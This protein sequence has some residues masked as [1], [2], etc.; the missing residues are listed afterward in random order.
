M[1]NVK[2]CYDVTEKL[3]ELLMNPV[4]GRDQMVEA[5]SELLDRREALLK[6]LAPP[7]TEEERQLGREMMA[8]Q[9][10]IDDKLFK[11]KADIQ[12]DMQQLRR[13][14]QSANKYTNPYSALQVD[15]VFYDKKN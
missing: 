8:R 3:Y 14:K 13:K 10:I 6:S 11:L 9:K 1:P 5:I 7:F 4:S 15:G 12:R 2:A